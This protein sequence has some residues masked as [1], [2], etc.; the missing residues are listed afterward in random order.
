MAHTRTSSIAFFTL[1]AVITSVS[2]AAGKPVKPPAVT[3]LDQKAAAKVLADESV[4]PFFSVM[5]PKE[6]AALTAG[7]AKG[8]NLTE[9]RKSCRDIF[10]GA[11]ASFT[12][13][14]K[15]ALTWLARQVSTQFMK[16]YPKFASLPWSFIK[17]SKPLAGGFPHT[18]NKQIVFTQALITNIVRSK[19]SGNE[20]R[21]I[22]AL[23]P[24]FVHEQ[25]HVFQRYNPK[26]MADLYTKVWKFQHIK[27]GI[28]S[29]QWLIDRNAS[30]PDGIDINWIIPVGKDKYLWPRAIFEREAEVNAMRDMTM[31]GVNV[32]KTKKGFAVVT[33]KNKKPVYKSLHRVNAYKEMFPT[34]RSLY[35]PNEI[36]ADLMAQIYLI[37]VTTPNLSQNNRFAKAIA[38]M[39]TWCLKNFK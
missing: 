32:I 35:H 39:K 2:A 34:V 10:S 21:L 26:L 18:R 23:G 12:N 3:F 16:D 7:K 6:I 15:A 13:K 37:D 31:I 30:N 9:L 8:K 29:P 22:R 24:L 4:E 28:Q 20:K 33:D 17:L 11:A 14:E 5:Q 38:P 1:I 36:A 25:M 27:G 19:D